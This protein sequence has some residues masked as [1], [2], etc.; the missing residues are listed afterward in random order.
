MNN[1]VEYH[2]P[3]GVFPIVS[4]DLANRLPLQNLNWHSPPRP[5]RQIRSLH[6]DFVPDEATQSILKPQL[7]RANSNGPDS[8]DI[9]RSG[10][11]STRE[12]RH[13]I[14]G[15]QTSPYLK[16]YILRCDDKESYREHDRHKIREWLRNIA[17][18]EG[19][20]ADHDACEWLIIH[21]VIPDTV[22][23]SEPRWR[24]S[25]R[26]PEEL[27]E[28][29]GGTKWPGQSSRTVLDRL[30][31]DFNE[32][33]KTARD[34]VTQIRLVKGQMPADL[35]PTPAVA[36]TLEE[37]AQERENAWNDLISKFK[38]LILGPFD[39]RVRQYEAD[40][41]EQEARRS[42]PGFNF[43]TFFIHKE[44]L[45]KALESIG[46]V[47]DALAIY[48]E[49]SLG[50]ETVCREIA[51]G[52]AVSTAT[53]FATYTYDLKDRI[54]GSPGLQTNG[55][56]EF[57]TN[58]AATLFSKDY[59]ERIVRSDISVFDFMCY[60]YDRQKA[61]I[62]RLANSKSSRVDLGANP[63]RDG[64]EDL[65]LTS[66]VCWRASAFIHTAARVLRQDYLSGKSLTERPTM[67][68]EVESVVC[69]W[70]WAVAGQVLDQ[71]AAP[72]LLDITR[73][74]GLQ[75]TEMSKG[76]PKRPD[77]SIGMGAN[78]HPQRSASLPGIKHDPLE[79]MNPP[80]RPKTQ[81]DRPSSQSGLQS[82]KPIGLP[83]QAELAT[84]RAEL[85]MMRRKML[86]QFAAHQRWYAG[87]AFC[88]RA[89][90]GDLDDVKL[91][92]TAYPAQEFRGSLM[93]PTLKAA[94]EAEQSFQG[95]YEDLTTLAIQHYVAAT[96]T[97][98][99]ERLIGDLAV[100]KCQQNDNI[101]AVAYFQRILPE[102]SSENWDSIE[103]DVLTAY[104]SC[105]KKL[106]RRRDHVRV[107][108]GLISKIVAQ[109]KA[110]GARGLA[111]RSRSCVKNTDTATL[112]LDAIRASEGFQE[113]DT[114]PLRRY[115]EE[116][117]LSQE[118]VHNS[119][120]GFELSLRLTH[121][122]EHDVTFN[123]AFVRLI[124]VNDPTLVV[125]ATST[126]PIKLV[127]GKNTMD[128]KG[129]VVSYGAFLVDKIVLTAQKL[130]FVEEMRPEP[131][132]TPLGF[133]I[134]PPTVTVTD[135][136]KTP[137]FVFL[138][139]AEH[140]FVAEIKRASNV[141]I[142]RPRHLQVSLKAGQS[143][144]KMVEVRL[145][146]TS[147]GLRL[148]VADATVEGMDRASPGDGKSGQI[149][150]GSLASNA[151][152]QLSIP[153]TTEHANRDIGVRL[154][155]CYH[156]E[157]GPFTYLRT[158][159]LSN[160]LT[161]DVDVN[162]LFHIGTLY[163]SFTVRTT[164]QT[165]FSVLDADFRESPVYAVEK[166]P[167]LPLP[168]HVYKSQPMNLVY[169]ITRKPATV[170]ET[171]KRDAALAL[172]VTYLP[173][174]ELLF[175][176]LRDK[177]SNDLKLSS[178]SALIHLLNPLLLER[179]RQSI[180][181]ADL[182]MA[183][184]MGETRLPDFDTI[185]WRDLTRTLPSKVRDPLE[186]WLREWHEQNTTLIAI[187]GAEAKLAAQHITIS[188]DVPNVDVV[189]SAAWR[190]PRSQL[191]VGSDPVV[192]KLGQPL[193]AT[194]RIRFTKQWSAQSIFPNVP[195]VRIQGDVQTHP[196]FAA[197][198][199]AD[200]DTWLVGGPRRHH[201]T[202]QGNEMQSIDVLLVPLRLGRHALPLVE[203][204]RP[205]A[206][207]DGISNSGDAISVSCETHY[208]SAGKL[209]HVVRDSRT[210]TVYIPEAAM[211]GMDM[212]ARPDT[213]STNQL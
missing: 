189:F 84:Y 207:E 77:L 58:D 167:M 152:A 85:I 154:E 175:Y 16:V 147:A 103:L 173:T 161:L 44:G 116:V 33:G 192:V 25:T 67:N 52:R 38:T 148:Y 182:E 166:P 99:A 125:V 14:P 98:N 128:L 65:V 209:V 123:Q 168:L 171:L 183:A 146:P 48:D 153:Y 194:L 131:M 80:A 186:T 82:S 76:K 89:E 79:P 61:L 102:S 29:K 109:R 75:P 111:T 19:K 195:S 138:Y 117:H 96:Q 72:A 144:I 7:T 9:V 139:P 108:L 35:L 46:L 155:I 135:P 88:K 92:Q 197:E 15:L 129:K 53:S 106:E 28:R 191:A 124:A 187:D 62:L 45:A 119:M 149:K 210:S 86:E 78:S 55:S 113:E 26:D 160:E 43:C 104:C 50:L 202:L 27:K 133:T 107:A 193:Q 211:T 66:E 57:M 203:V 30:R 21:V 71:T 190:L 51:E 204:K 100:L 5:L 205:S 6:V 20:R 126:G 122:L 2:D 59:R 24:E 60:L 63:G 163:S 22:A 34:R 170:K 1:A 68:N 132:P 11:K 115:F 145:K 91:G 127:P 213:A 32:T 12:R 41:A 93:G 208:A 74:E 140:S 39:R 114:Q 199:E 49:L 134:Q 188:V 47:E 130:Q 23:A 121:V 70:T 184:I 151:A 64:G 40:I 13:Q 3:S 177:F 90:R 54:S 206:D 162:D 141:H 83:G 10:A 169:K 159:S 118:I 174:D 178:F 180:L 181:G 143:S 137:P 136:S 95:L 105:L 164:T 176:S 87:W 120:E 42:L 150:L 200:A 110:T 212:V 8:L 4:R 156:T 101:A 31:S 69:S 158:A 198:I 157:E 17:V 97:K 112:W 179:F 142:D 73:H 56:D 36:I 37:S 94:L 172:D 81:A 185:G 196:V 165:P 201:F 18:P